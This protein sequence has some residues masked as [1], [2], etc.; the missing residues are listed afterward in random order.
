MEQHGGALLKQQTFPSQVFPY[1]LEDLLSQLVLLQKVAE[2]QD[3][4]GIRD[5]VA[6][7]INFIDEYLRVNEK[8]C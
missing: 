5:V 6:D 4:G 2:R 7:Q 1:C 3:G 8:D